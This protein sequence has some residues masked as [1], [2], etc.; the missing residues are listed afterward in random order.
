MPPYWLDGVLPLNSPT[1]LR[2]AAEGNFG[3]D[4]PYPDPANTDDLPENDD[5]D[6]GY[7]NW[8]A[9][10]NWEWSLINTVPA[11]YGWQYSRSTEGTYPANPIPN[12]SIIGTPWIWNSND[13]SESPGSIGLI[14]QAWTLLQQS[15][16]P[17]TLTDLAFHVFM[18]SIWKA[19]WHDEATVRARTGQP[20]DDDTKGI[21]TDSV[22][23]AIG[24]IRDVAIL[25]RAAEWAESNPNQTTITEQIDID[26][27]G[28]SE[29]VMRNNRL[30]LVFEDD[31]GRLVRAFS[32]DANSGEVYEIVG[33]S[34]VA[35]D[36][37]GE[38]EGLDHYVSN[39]PDVEFNRASCFRE[40][41]YVNQPYLVNIANKDLLFYTQDLKIKRR[42]SLP[43]NS[44]YINV[45]Y[46]L[47]RSTPLL[48]E[49]CFSPNPRATM[50]SGKAV[51]QEI[52]SPYDEFIG[53]RNIYGGA[54]YIE[55]QDAE[56]VARD[57]LD[58]R[59]TL[60]LAQ[61]FVISVQNIAQLRIGFGNSWED[62]PP[63]ILGVRIFG[64]PMDSRSGGELRIEAITNGPP[65]ERVRLLYA[66]SPEKPLTPPLYLFDL[67]DDGT[68]G[69]RIAGDGIYSFAASIPAGTAP[70]DRYIL[71]V[72]AQDAMGNDSNPWPFFTVTG[73]TATSYSSADIDDLVALKM[74]P[75]HNQVG[76]SPGSPY[77]P[78]GA[79]LRTHVSQTGGGNIR[80]YVQIE[81]PDGP[82][83]VFDAEV[84][85]AGIRTGI[86]LTSIG[87]SFWAFELEMPPGIP[88]GDY[89]L[90]VEARDIDGNRSNLWP[91]W[92][93]R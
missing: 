70:Q 53:I 55:M 80:C 31:G 81:D 48:V 2:D 89:L 23:A 60:P 83:D 22:M 25:T 39:E 8:W 62:R 57:N 7:Q 20:Q 59:A 79:Y 27:D 85:Y 35:P 44:D 32:R 4:N 64:S 11:Q 71:A 15:A 28:E 6:D 68:A 73:D 26:I 21:I 74:E 61:R 67:A 92:H 93:V 54:A 77:I 17:N 30:F 10:S 91:T 14:P 19:G 87:N 49:H 24:H 47:N 38:D 72:D 46:E 41:G 12:G 37:P 90:G 56:F 50:L 82:S 34:G 52:G 86:Y 13:A 45:K 76:L 63:Q 58:A 51:L 78:F 65:P 33:A 5:W 36:W 9:G 18:C 42:I 43:D 84:C 40:S 66:G 69:D 88:A 1:R 29:W 3:D 75:P 16:S